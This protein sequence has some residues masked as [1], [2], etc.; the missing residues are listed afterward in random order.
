MDM[1]QK[2][3]LSTQPDHRLKS[4]QDSV[5]L[6]GELEHVRRHAI[7]SANSIRHQLLDNPEDEELAEREM[8]YEVIAENCKQIRRTFME[9]KFNFVDDEDW[10]L[11]KGTAAM[12]QLAYELMP[13]TSKIL[14]MTEKLIDATWGVA[15]EEDMSGCKS[16]KEDRPDDNS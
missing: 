9:D 2:S 8:H 3:I 5:S 6:V 7:R 1:S 14:D 15:L 13:S 12:R 11:L 4:L 16:C 10:C